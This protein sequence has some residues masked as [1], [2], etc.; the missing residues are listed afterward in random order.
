MQASAEPVLVALAKKNK[1]GEFRVRILPIR[2]RNLTP[3]AA[4]QSVSLNR[5]ATA[6]PTMTWAF[7]AT[8]MTAHLRDW[9]RSHGWQGCCR[10]GVSRDGIAVSGTPF[11]RGCRRSYTSGIDAYFFTPGVYVCYSTSTHGQ[12]EHTL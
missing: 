11:I 12:L 1:S 10:S 5:L 3:V 6:R 4:K 9:R 8:L 2:Q 7:A